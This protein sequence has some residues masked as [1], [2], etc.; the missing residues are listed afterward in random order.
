MCLCAISHRVILLWHF[1]IFG[2]DVK[3]KTIVK[4]HIIGFFGHCHAAPR[5]K[6]VSEST[7]TKL[8]IVFI[9]M[10]CSVAVHGT[11]RSVNETIFAGFL[12]EL[13]YDF[14]ENTNIFGKLNRMQD[15][16][17]IIAVI[18]NNRCCAGA[19]SSGD[20]KFHSRLKSRNGVFLLE[21]LKFSSGPK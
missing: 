8:W 3:V 7:D 5:Q 20:N 19:L 6:R 10:F 2:S 4:L 15:S 1:M 14:N 21:A 17:I 11:C 9:W 16:S 18:R 12:A 13:N